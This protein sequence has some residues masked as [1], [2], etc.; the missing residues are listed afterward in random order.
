M[1]YV[2]NITGG[3]DNSHIGIVQGAISVLSGDLS[4][5]LEIHIDSN[6]GDPDAAKQVFDLLAPYRGRTTAITNAKCMSSAVLIYLAA[7]TRLAG[8]NADFMIHP[9]SWTL[10]GAY[11]FLKTY[12]SLNT[13]DLTLTLAE[14]YTLQA[15]LNTATKRLLE[16]EEYTDEI[17]RT[18][19]KLTEKQFRDRGSV[20][21]DQHF[22]PA[23]SLQLGISTGLI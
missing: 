20:N 12:R 2:I 13:G 17:F 4:L 7:D 10:W 16:I 5:E 8:P 22:T 18:R 11:S 9:T 14:V 3:I 1:S 19:A 6:G 15:Q 21:T 23:E